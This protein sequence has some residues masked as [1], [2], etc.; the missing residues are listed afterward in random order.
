MS[1]LNYRKIFSEST[2]SLTKNPLTIFLS[3]LLVIIPI[4]IAHVTNLTKT[5][6]LA[7]FVSTVPLLLILLGAYYY[8]VLI[9][10]KGYLKT[11]NLVNLK[12][13]VIDFANF[14][15][16]SLVSGFIV[17]I[18]ALP[19]I[20]AILVFSFAFYNVILPYN[21][22]NFTFNDFRLA[23]NSVN[24]YFYA[25][26]TIFLLN[27]PLIS[28]IWYKV[29]L[30]PYYSLSKNLSPLEAVKENIEDSKS[31]D[32]VDGFLVF[33]ILLVIDLIAS[34]II[35]TLVNNV[36]NPGNSSYLNWL[37]ILIPFALVPFQAHQLSTIYNQI[38]KKDLIG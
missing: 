1:N 5:S 33:L 18:S 17:L 11:V 25:A 34:W 10:V 31:L 13:S 19:A 20:L 8:L 37:L 12:T 7:Y 21:K 23:L 3:T 22:I 27:L 9:T 4:A 29:G 32:Y 16:T 24:T 30:A 26:I 6:N 36:I 14:V 35:I 38:S 2:K 28:Y 15:L